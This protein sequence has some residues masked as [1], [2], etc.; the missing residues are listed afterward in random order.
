MTSWASLSQC[1]ADCHWCPPYILFKDLFF[2]VAPRKLL[3]RP[4]E[5]WSKDFIVKALSKDVY[6]EELFKALP[7][8]QNKKAQLSEKEP[9]L[10]CISLN[11]PLLIYSHWLKTLLPSLSAESELRNKQLERTEATAKTVESKHSV[12]RHDAYPKT[13][14]RPKHP[15]GKKLCTRIS[16]WKGKECHRPVLFCSFAPLC[17]DLSINQIITFCPHP[18]SLSALLSCTGC[19]MG[20]PRLNL[21]SQTSSQLPTTLTWSSQWAELQETET[22]P[23]S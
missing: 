21:G 6:I 1:S 10:S 23:T 3:I 17:S 13:Y 18:G 12:K 16:L 22:C 2:T 8:W 20:S 11:K 15:L 9:G 5:G 14:L 7:D 19:R 4:S